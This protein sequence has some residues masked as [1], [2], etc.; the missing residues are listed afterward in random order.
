MVDPAGEQSF[1]FVGASGAGKTTIA[2]EFCRIGWRYLSDEV[3]GIRT[4][5]SALVGFPKPLTVKSGL[6]ETLGLDLASLTVDVDNQRRWYI[7]PSLLGGS[8]ASVAPRPTDLVVVDFDPARPGEELI[9][10][11]PQQALFE[12]LQNTFNVTKHGAGLSAALAQAVT[13]A[14]LW[15]LAFGNPRA[16]A[17]LL[18]ETAGRV[19]QPH[20]N[21]T[22]LHR[23]KSGGDQRGPSP[24][25]TAA[26]VGF[27]GAGAVV[28]DPATSQ[29]IML[30]E[31]ASAIWAGLDGR[32]TTGELTAELGK[33]FA[34]SPGVIAADV[35]AVVVDLITQGW[36]VEP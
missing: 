20:Y 28:H 25:S 3:I 24:V 19:E 16:A 35:E 12:L 27:E 2:A 17:S 1:L 8:T 9:A 13:H 36:L 31:T 18:I 32:T 15:R 21:T 14:R 26:F 10:L 5:D 30:D 33:T 6:H 29:A 11:E 7:R 4:D 22:Q 23:P 34:A